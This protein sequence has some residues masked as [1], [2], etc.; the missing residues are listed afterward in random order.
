MLR[1]RLRLLCGLRMC[2]HLLLQ[3]LHMLP[4]ERLLLSRLRLS[5]KSPCVGICLRLRLVV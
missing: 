2:L 4:R 5:G 3:C 1:L